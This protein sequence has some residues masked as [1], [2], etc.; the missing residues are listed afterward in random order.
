V[1]YFQGVF[2]SRRGVASCFGIRVGVGCCCLV[3]KIGDGRPDACGKSYPVP[4]NIETLPTHIRMVVDD[5]L[6]NYPNSD[7]VDVLAGKKSF[8][9]ALGSPAD[10]KAVATTANGADILRGPSRK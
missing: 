2:S 6:L 8:Q 7:L 10:R 5:H 9:D 3:V 4:V 1:D